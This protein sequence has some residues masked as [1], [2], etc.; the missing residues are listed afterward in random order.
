MTYI[1]TLAHDTRCVRQP[2]P[3]FFV[4]E[5]SYHLWDSQHVC[6]GSSYLTGSPDLTFVTDIR[7]NHAARLIH[8]VSSEHPQYHGSLSWT[9]N[10]AY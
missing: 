6:R 10:G 5:G 3:L 2:F 4:L 8:P 9:V 1:D 7:D